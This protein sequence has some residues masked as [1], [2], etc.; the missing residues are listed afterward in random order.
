MCKCSGEEKE[1][2][3]YLLLDFGHE[4]IIRCCNSEIARKFGKNEWHNECEK[5]DSYAKLGSS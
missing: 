5:F 1:R 2:I 3:Y 4:T